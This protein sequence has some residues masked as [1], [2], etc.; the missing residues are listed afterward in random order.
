MITRREALVGGASV[1]ALGGSLV[2][3]AESS[4]AAFSIA[5][6][7]YPLIDAHCHIFNAADIPG[8]NF[9]Y[10]CFF[11]MYGDDEV[12]AKCIPEEQ[13]GWVERNFFVTPLI[14]LVLPLFLA[15]VP[16]RKE[17]AY[18][19]AGEG[20]SKSGDEEPNGARALRRLFT[21][22]K[23]G[24]K[25]GGSAFETDE[26]REEFARFVLRQANI[27]P[28][29]EGAAAFLETDKGAN[30]TFD[31][32]V[33]G[34]G[35]AK[36]GGDDEE[37]SSELGRYFAWA[38][39]LSGR[40]MD[41]ADRLSSLYGGPNHKVRLHTPA[42]VDYSK[43]LDQE[44]KTGSQLSDQ[45]E[46]MEQLTIY[47]ARTKGVLFHG[48]M[49]FDP[50]R[51]V[52]EGG[53]LQRVK[54]AVGYRSGDG[55]PVPGQGFIG[56]KVYPPMGFKATGNAGD[57][58]ITFPDH[59]LK[60]VLGGAKTDQEKEAA[61]A[62]LRVALDEKL[63]ELYAWCAQDK[64]PILSHA[65]DSYGAGPCYAKRADP[66]NWRAVV[67]KHKSLRVCLGHLGEFQQ[68]IPKDKDPPTASWKD[69]EKT[70]EWNFGRLLEDG[71]REGF[72]ENVYADMS[73]FSDVLH[74][75]GVGD[76]KP[77]WVKWMKR[78]EFLPQRLIYGSDWILLDQEKNKSKH[79]ARVYGFLSEVFAE[80]FGEARRAELLRD[81][82]SRNAIRF[83]GVD[84]TGIVPTQPGEPNT[85]R[86]LLAFY[87]RNNLKPQCTSNGQ[88]MDCGTT[89]LDQFRLK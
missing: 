35:G 73:Y 14:E 43:W 41:I 65:Y 23:G 77:A 63:D 31:A 38:G 54:V 39:R 1:L 3:A 24:S 78:F 20:G 9:L 51:E 12:A 52:L 76:V 36:S 37:P 80:A 6:I 55:Q 21:E 83:L 53:A 89:F 82:F 15:A 33:G 49:A 30:E 64:V 84:P 27:T 75:S 8:K 47:F 70:W 10:R 85:A 67:K 11:H 17:L 61:K 60:Q 29:P 69:L 44:L 87:E 71:R 45:A 26:Q 28:P 57:A 22:G 62:R 16:A 59:V 79:L 4:G 2:G 50:L 42:L 48:Y 86:R 68:A 40:R 13:P 56:A 66:E 81:V 32:L 72:G 88:T 74:D 58:S 25:S 19:K 5:D 34:S 7:N 46:V 18:L